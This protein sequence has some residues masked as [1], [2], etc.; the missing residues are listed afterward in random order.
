MQLMSRGWYHV[1]H[2]HADQLALRN[3]CRLKTAR[4]TERRLALPCVR[5]SG[6]AGTHLGKHLCLLIERLPLGVL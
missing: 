5:D 2:D 6:H 4:H 1:V 3:S